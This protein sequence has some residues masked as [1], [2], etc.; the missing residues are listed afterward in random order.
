ME[1]EVSKTPI[2]NEDHKVRFNKMTKT[3]INLRGHTIL[4]EKEV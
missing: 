1:N 3:Q 4:T 2:V